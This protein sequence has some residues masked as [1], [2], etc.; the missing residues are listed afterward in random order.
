MTRAA[1]LG[2]LLAAVALGRKRVVLTLIGGGVFQNPI[3]LIWESIEW[4]LEEVRPFLSEDLDVV[5]NGYALAHQVNL[6]DYV[7]PA[8]RK[9]GGALLMFGKHG[10]LALQL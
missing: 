4:A 3:G 10:L 8:V 6:D 9:R 1:Y 2:T 5:V 7:L